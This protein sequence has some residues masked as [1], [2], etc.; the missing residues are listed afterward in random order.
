MFGRGPRRD[1]STPKEQ[2]G[3]QIASSRSS[4]PPPKFYSVVV[5]RGTTGFN[6]EYLLPDLDYPGRVL[7]SECVLEEWVNRGWTGVVRG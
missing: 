1:E 5:L 4:R 3:F 2:F 6:G 7:V